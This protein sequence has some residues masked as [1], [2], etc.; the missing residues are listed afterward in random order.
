[1]IDLPSILIT[2]DDAEFR[3][4]LRGVFEPEGYR[5]LLAGDGEEALEIVHR[6][7]VHLILLDM[8]MPKLSG[9]ELLLLVRDFSALLP[10]IMLSAD[11]DAAIV[12]QAESADV[13]AIL[14]KPVTRHRIVAEVETAMRHVYNWPA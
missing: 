13:F 3:E 9:L 10:C 12:E 1:M 5:T 8:H 2:D 6:E 4:T 7:E 14:S 11:L